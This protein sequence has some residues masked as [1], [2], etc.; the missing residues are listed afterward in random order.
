MQP[1]TMGDFRA[2]LT[3]VA[4]YANYVVA[5]VVKQFASCNNVCE[6]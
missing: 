2:R 3:I 6:T 4:H 1:L 5:V